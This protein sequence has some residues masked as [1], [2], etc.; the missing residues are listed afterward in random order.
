MAK[1]KKKSKASRAREGG[2][3]KKKPTLPDPGLPPQLGTRRS[4][5]TSQDWGESFLSAYTS[6]GEI[7]K[8][9]A[10]AGIGRQTFYD[11]KK[12]DPEFA[13]KV[14]EIQEAYR[15]TY[16]EDIANAVI[17]RCF[18]GEKKTVVVQKGGEKTVTVVHSY[19]ARREEFVLK[20]LLP[21]MF[22]DDARG[23]ADTPDEWA[24][25]ARAA[26]EAMLATLDVEND[27]ED[28]G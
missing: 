7:V 21:A 3:K 26:V 23:D 25:A 9:C 11:R 24:R 6:C 12:A 27:E 10:S 4:R 5:D 16:A 19:D 18:E 28:A 14:A 1:R 8:A 15:M 20:K 2:T 22:G 13:M 17:R